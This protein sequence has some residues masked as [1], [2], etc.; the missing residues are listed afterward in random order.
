MRF[1]TRGGPL[2]IGDGTEQ[3]FIT[4]HYWGYAAQKDGST[5][6]YQ[7]EHPRWRVWE[8]ESAALH[9]N[10]TGLY[11]EY[12][13]EHLSGQPSSAFLAEGSVVKV[14]RGRILSS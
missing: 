8:T 4:E 1:T 5:I 13:C 9:C 6:E 11:G 10:V 7:V 12:F 3:E 2:P 14:F